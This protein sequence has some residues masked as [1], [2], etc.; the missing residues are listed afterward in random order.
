MTYCKHVLEL[1]LLLIIQVTLVIQNVFVCQGQDH[2]LTLLQLIC[3]V[4]HLQ[5]FQ[6]TQ[7]CFFIFFFLLYITSM[8]KGSPLTQLIQNLLAFF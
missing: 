8:A 1:I 7:L 3:T 6:T 5:T 2:G 4:F